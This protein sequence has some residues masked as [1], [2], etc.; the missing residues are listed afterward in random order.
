V[1]VRDVRLIEPTEEKT[2][3]ENEEEKRQQKE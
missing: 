1:Q 3:K 2:A